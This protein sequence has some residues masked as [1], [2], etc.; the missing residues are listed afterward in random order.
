MIYSSVTA[1]SCRY[2]VTAT[3]SARVRVNVGVYQPESQH[4][5]CRQSFY[6]LQTLVYRY[7]CHYYYY[8]FKM[9]WE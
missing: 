8:Y 5:Q 2:D 3:A 9:Y 1:S 6:P 4:L 7:Y